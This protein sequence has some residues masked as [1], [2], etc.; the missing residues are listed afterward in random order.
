MANFLIVGRKGAIDPF[1]YRVLLAGLT[2]MG[3][4]GFGRP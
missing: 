2:W 4:P 3:G 1:T